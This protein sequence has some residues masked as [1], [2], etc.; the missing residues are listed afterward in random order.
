MCDHVWIFEARTPSTTILNDSG[1]YL[2]AR[3]ADFRRSCW[4]QMRSHSDR[5]ATNGDFLCSVKAVTTKMEDT[6]RRAVKTMTAEE[7]R[8]AANG[9]QDDC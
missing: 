5:P 9:N 1:R 2:R 8:T 6:L 4:A 3:E 7:R